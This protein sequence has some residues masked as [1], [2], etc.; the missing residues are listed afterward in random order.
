MH[1]FN[2]S[3]NNLVLPKPDESDIQQQKL[4][5]S[6]VIKDPIDSFKIFSI[7]YDVALKMINE[8]IGSFISGENTN[9]RCCISG[10]SGSGKTRLLRDVLEIYK[11]EIESYLIDSISYRNYGLGELENFILDILKKINHESTA[12]NHIQNKSLKKLLIID[13]I[14]ILIESAYLTSILRYNLKNIKHNVCILFAVS[15]LPLLTCTI[16]EA[17][18]YHKDFYTINIEKVS[19]NKN[20]VFS[21][22]DVAENYQNKMFRFNGPNDLRFIQVIYYKLIFE[23]N[24]INRIF[25]YKARF[26]WKLLFIPFK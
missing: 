5:F 26:D 14:D 13:N 17:Y 7:Q 6:P 23:F 3:L 11:Q 18:Q 20:I 10:P 15:N 24:M 22:D 21:R 25:I 1:S 2:I 9:F 4:V 8:S 16:L 19:N 12:L